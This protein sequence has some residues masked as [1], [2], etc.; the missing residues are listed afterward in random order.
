MNHST[1]HNVNLSNILQLGIFLV[2]FIIETYILGFSVVVSLITIVHVALA[3]YLRSQM[4]I[5]KNSIEGLAGSMKN[6]CKGN[7]D[8]KAPIEGKGEIH[9]LAIEFNSMLS[10]INHYLKETIQAV[11]VAEDVDKSYY[12][13]TTSLNPLLKEA[14]ETINDSVKMI[15]EGY[16]SR[17]RGDFTE[18]LHD[19]GGGI[20]HGLTLIQ[21]NLLNN[22]EEVNKI[23][24]MSNQTSDEANKSLNSMENILELFN[25]LSQ[26]I[27]S[28]NHN[29]TGLSERSNEISSIADIIKDIAE[30]TNLLALN[31]AIEAA[32]AG[33]H[34]R[35]FAVV[36]DEVRKLAERTQKSTQEIS[37]T[38]QTLQQET[39]EI[40]SHSEDMTEIAT[41]ATAKIDE[42][43]QTLG[44]FQVNAQ[45]SANYASYI[46][47][48]LFMILVK[49]DHILFKSNAY[50]SV[51]GQKVTASFGDHKACRLGKW[52]LGD[53]KERYGHTN[54]YSSVDDPHAKVHANVLKNIE[55]VKDGSIKDMKSREYVISNFRNM[56]NESE[57]LF[58][59][60]DKV[61]EE[62]DPTKR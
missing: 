11:K 55:M 5:V 7:F 34:G 62:L 4:L 41:N 59:I 1:L 60:L 22:S 50:A 37:V 47:D 24:Q 58:E 53:G 2:A 39:Q 19:L 18:K 54:N 28:T 35:G 44:E 32:R 9:D 40:Q 23:S 8:V 48:S 33:E 6:V 20:A 15:E 26:K 43:S 42:F 46:R 25:E 45:D 31:A 29:I 10:Q 13:D 61:I 56:E 17:V 49:I 3:L 14:A 30:Q 16:Q 57:K 38:I 27:D 36:A 12:A 52:Y 21:N 51:I